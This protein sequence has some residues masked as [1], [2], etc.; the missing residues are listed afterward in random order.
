MNYRVE[1][2]SEARQDMR[3]IYAYIA[4]KLMV[5]ETAEGQVNRIMDAADELEEMPLRF[6]LYEFEPWR[7]QGLRFVPV[8]NYILFYLP[9]EEM[10][11]VYIVRIMYGGRDIRRQLKETLKL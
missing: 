8:D 7:S 5:P 6:S 4:E 2:T 11:T 10:N 3:D 1:Y 9:R